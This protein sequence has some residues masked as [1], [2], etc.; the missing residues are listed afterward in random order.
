MKVKKIRAEEE[1]K[2]IISCEKIQSFYIITITLQSKSIISK[3]ILQS[4]SSRERRPLGHLGYTSDKKKI[5][6]G[7]TLN[8]L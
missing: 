2:N 1:S 5:T 6:V 4:F 3:S 7:L 8:Q